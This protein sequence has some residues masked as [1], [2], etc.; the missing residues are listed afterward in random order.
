MILRWTTSALRSQPNLTSNLTPRRPQ[1]CLSFNVT[2]TRT[3]STKTLPI[4][5]ASFTETDIESFKRAAF[6]A[7]KPLVL[8]QDSKK[9]RSSAFDAGIRAVDRAFQTGLPVP[10]DLPYEL[11]ADRDGVRWFATF[12][13]EMLEKRSQNFGSGDRLSQ[14]ARELNDAIGKHLN[15]WTDMDI[16]SRQKLLMR[17]MFGFELLGELSQNLHEDYE[18]ARG[19][20]SIYIA[21]ADLGYLSRDLPIPP[22]VEQA[23]KG[24]VYKSS[25]WMGLG[26]TYTPWHRDP[27]PNYFL[28]LVG[29]K[30][31]RILPPKRGQALFNQ[32]MA[33][34]PVNER[35]SS[36]IRGEE[37]MQGAQRDALT[38]AV[39]GKE[40]REGILTTVLQPGDALFIPQGWWHSLKGVGE[41]RYPFWRHANVS[42]NWWF[43]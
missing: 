34:I 36:R 29:S 35:S 40:A 13:K 26:S 30:D 5:E 38:E 33:M 24:D 27:N 18:G 28:Q 25:I 10:V 17:F 19:I 31:V 4:P 14:M 8:C 43:R 7:Q 23:G 39:W 20:E 37:M 22:Y 42:C 16:P 9:P 3:H 2:K 1:R 41:E 12:C 15:R 6:D 11:V 32:A 21:Q